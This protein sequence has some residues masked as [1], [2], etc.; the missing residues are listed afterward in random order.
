LVSDVYELWGSSVDLAQHCDPGGAA[1]TKWAVVGEGPGGKEC[2]QNRG[3]VG[4]SGELLWPL[5]E[6]FAGVR[7]EQCWVTNLCKH[8][9]DDTLPSDKKL[10]PA[11][12]ESCRAELLEELTWIAQPKRVL[13]VGS[14]A[15]RALMG[16]AFTTM[17][18]CNGMAWVDPHFER[19]WT[20]VPCFHPAAALRGGGE[21]KLGWTAKAIEAW[22]QSIEATPVSDPR[23]VAIDTEGWPNDPIMLTFAYRDDG[24]RLGSGVVYPSGVPSWW[25]DTMTPDT[26]IIWHNA[27]WDWRVVEAM[28]VVDPW[29]QPF[30]DTM[31]RAYVRTCEPQGLK[32]LAWK[33]L[34]VK[35]RDYDDVV[36]PYWEEIVKAYAEGL[37]AASTS[38]VHKPL[39][40]GGVS[41]VGKVVVEEAAKPIKRVLGNAETLAERLGFGGPSLRYVPQAEA[42]AYAM[43]DAICTLRLR[44]VL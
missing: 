10:T 25:Q 20:V 30:E 17:D 44:E 22:R 29:V 19:G 15:A 16:D 34:G 28:G 14:L 23:W 8:R 9:L 26:I 24:G 18:A 7:R 27:L 4:Q 11:E 13:A 35:M 1:P 42:E 38:V 33:H 6:R 40:R 43:S 31:E 39:K 41:K 36:R 2:D 3:F 12:F 21:G 37:V 5:V 32:A